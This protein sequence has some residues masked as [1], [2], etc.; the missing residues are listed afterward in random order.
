[1]KQCALHCITDMLYF[2]PVGNEIN[3]K[4]LKLI[5]NL[6]QFSKP[7]GYMYIIYK[8]MQFSC[9]A[10]ASYVLLTFISGLE[11]ALAWHTNSSK[12]HSRLARLT[13]I[14]AWWASK[15]VSNLPVYVWIYMLS[16]MIMI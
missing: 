10:N 12:N 4:V 7:Y 13:L 5:Q 6:D 8:D 11:I 9:I 15:T 1:M 16:S 2:F 14:V 3:L